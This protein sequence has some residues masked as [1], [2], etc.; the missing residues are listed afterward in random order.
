MIVSRTD[1]KG[2]IQYI[3]RDFIEISGFTEA[4]L[5]GSPHNIV[6]H[7]DMPPEAFADF[8]ETLKSGR[9][10]TGMVKNR[11]KNGD[12]YWVEANA[13]PVRENGAVVGYMSV[14]RKPTREQVDAAE[15]AYRALREGARDL[16][17]RRGRIV[18]RGRMARTLQR[19]HDTSVRARGMALAGAFV[20]LQI[21]TAL[22]VQL[23]AA[24]LPLLVLAGAAASF[25][26]C[27]WF[28]R[29]VVGP[30]AAAH[31]HF[32]EMS[33][34]RLDVRIA[35][36]REDE[37]GRILD[38]A[39]T[40]QIKLGFDMAEGKRQAE[41]TARVKQG[42]DVVAT[43]V[44]VADADYNIVY[45]NHSIQAMLAEAEA[46]IRKDL[47]SFSAKNVVGTN[48]DA[49]HKNPAY[50]RGLLGKL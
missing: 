26:A 45:V 19:L 38:A 46:D 11:C 49:F 39:R 44:M 37:I 30:L 7:P 15:K 32:L 29:G 35:V 2:I 34:G 23:G 31:R 1:T 10:W 4:E 9:P 14:R 3:N 5:I 40:M 33:E 50:Q 6:R 28:V 17:V 42:L 43:N 24:A 47:P 18:A 20:A 16:A 21:A 27:W 41:E 22:A 36:D 25:G 12:H 8:W 48:I 13:T